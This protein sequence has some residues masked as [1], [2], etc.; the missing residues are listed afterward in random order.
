MLA[1]IVILT[2]LILLGMA[3]SEQKNSRFRKEHK[4][5]YFGQKKKYY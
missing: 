2:F 3:K 5:N 4:R 1:V